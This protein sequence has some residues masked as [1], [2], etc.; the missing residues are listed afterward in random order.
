MRTER[1][2]ALLLLLG[3]GLLLPRVACADEVE[4]PRR[5][6]PPPRVIVI[7]RGVAP[8]GAAPLATAPEPQ[9]APR[10]AWSTPVA[11]APG[12][13]LPRV[14]V[15]T[16]TPPAP[17]VVPAVVVPVR[18]SAP[19]PLGALFAPRPRVPGTPACASGG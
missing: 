14:A 19:A 8:T 2:V 4:P 9:P 16:A 12:A 6:L 15:A 5:E 1:A 7:S 11:V 18:P 10:V 13:P 3:L 17:P